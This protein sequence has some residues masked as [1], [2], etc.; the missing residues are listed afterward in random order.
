MAAFSVCD[1]IVI[2]RTGSLRPAGGHG[3]RDS[4][5]GQF[6]ALLAHHCLPG[7][8]P[9]ALYGNW[10]GAHHA[11]LLCQQCHLSDL[12]SCRTGCKCWRESI[13]LTYIV[14]AL[15]ALML[16]N[17]APTFP[18]GVDFAVMSGNYP[19]SGHRRRPPLPPCSSSRKL[20]DWFPP[21]AF[22]H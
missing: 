21:K 20:A 1:K 17:G 11:A 5:R 9:R 7:Q 10:A 14:D 12:P 3:G 6:L 2:Y 18:L 22:F 4:G 15:R 8:D 13:P 19:D 16:S